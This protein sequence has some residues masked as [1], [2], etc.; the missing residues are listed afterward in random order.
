M[1]LTGTFWNIGKI[2]W[3]YFYRL[4]RTNLGKAK[5]FFDD[6]NPNAVVKVHEW[7]LTIERANVALFW[8][9]LCPVN[10]RTWPTKY[11][12]NAANIKRQTIE[13]V[14]S[15]ERMLIFSSFLSLFL[16][17]FLSLLLIWALF[18]PCMRGKKLGL[19]WQPKKCKKIQY[20]NNAK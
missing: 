13:E 11:S 17:P 8:T 7:T 18:A 5:T 16:S 9:L 12:M 1:I 2:F 4:C 15:N 6:L 20:E 3:T 10:L 19:L 14:K